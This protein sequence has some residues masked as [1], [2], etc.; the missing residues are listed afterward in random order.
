[1][2]KLFICSL[3][4]CFF[5]GSTVCA[6][7]ANNVSDQKVVLNSP[8]LNL[9][10]GKSYGVSAANFG[11]ILKQ[12][13]DLR[14]RIYGISQKNGQRFGLFEFNGQKVT[15]LDLC[16]IESKIE[17][18]YNFKMNYL[19]KN[20]V[21]YSKEEIEKE[22]REITRAYQDQKEVLSVLLDVAKDDFM[23]VSAKY[24][25]GIRGIKDTLLGLIEEFVEKKA[26]THCFLLTWGSCKADEE[27]ENIR[28]RL[29]TFKDFTKFCIELTDFL[30][31]M[32]NS[33]PKGKSL[34]VKM[35]KASKQCK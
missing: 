17:S 6:S 1:M 14:R 15:L 31:A 9:I 2:K 33:C 25:D 20:E 21:N 26:L 5:I 7:N 22:K 3:L 28:T 30:E 13:L 8:L 11:L 16:E 32:A 12:R 19:A 34:F 4:S 18:E 29:T 24:A 27:E 10:D 23:E 35:I